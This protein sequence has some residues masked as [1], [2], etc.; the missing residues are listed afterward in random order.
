MHTQ[1]S[2]RESEQAAVNSFPTLWKN[3]Q[4][5]LLLMAFTLS[6]FGNSFHNIA[7]NL[8]ILTKTGSAK[9]MTVVLVTN[10]VI[11]SLLGPIAGTVA[12]RFNRRKIMLISNLNRCGFVLIAAFCISVPNI[13]IFIIVIL[14]GL[15]TAIGLFHS[16]A[17]HASLVNIVGKEHIQRAV[18]LMNISENI[19]RIVGFAVGGIFVTAF[20]GV[21]AIIFDGLTFLISFALIFIAG[22]FPTPTYKESEKKKFNEDL[23]TGF[24]YIWKDPF[25]KAVTILSPV[26]ALFFMSSLMLTQVMAVKVW[27]ADPF[28]F[29]LIES[30]I[31]MGYMLGAGIIVVFGS[32]LIKRGKFVIINLLL[33]GP[34][35]IFLSFS[36][37]VLVAIPIILLIG[38]MFSFCTMLINIILRLEVSEELQ[39]R[40]FGILGSLMSVAPSLGLGLASYFADL[41]GSDSVMFVIGCMLLVFGGIS[42]IWLKNIREYN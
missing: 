24:R 6:L 9:M 34:G 38:F 31:P 17:F 15:V 36:S 26:L 33:M 13:P 19:S 1:I 11:S 14:T 29:G 10:L 2:V 20:G 30:S 41:Y 39:G 32:K 16:P 27:N 3:R 21:W 8:W 7:L 35:Y 42:S 22:S 12:D 40:V 4:Y 5:N 28:Q 18:G 23:I 25:A 37:S